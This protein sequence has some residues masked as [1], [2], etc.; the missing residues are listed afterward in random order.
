MGSFLLLLVA[1]TTLVATKRRDLHRQ[2]GLAAFVIVPALVVV[3]FL[4]AP[5]MYHSAWN[6][7][8]FAP[9]ELQE[10]MRQGLL[11][12]ENNVLTQFRIGLL[13]PVF[14]FIGLKAREVDSGLHNDDLGNSC[15]ASTRNR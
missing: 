8:Q 15:R 14:I 3:G 12:R 9:P 11:R 1:Q 13:F 2:L 10:N 6:A 7:A 5:T 4:L